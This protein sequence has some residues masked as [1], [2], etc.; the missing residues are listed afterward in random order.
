MNLSPLDVVFLISLVVL[1]FIPWRKRKLWRVLFLIVLAINLG[2]RFDYIR[3]SHSIE[4]ELRQTQQYSQ[5][6]QEELRG[7]QQLAQAPVLTLTGHKMEKI[8]EGYRITLQF[9]SSKNEPLGIIAF[10]A[11]ILGDSDAKIIDFWPI[12]SAG[13]FEH[14]D[15]AKEISSDGKQARLVYSLLSATLP[16]VDLTISKV[17]PLEIQGNYITDPVM[18]TPK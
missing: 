18:I 10:Q 2:I 6:L 15:D 11:T 13:A 7:T 3:N 8:D 17:A 1:V 14:G 5:S 16:T 4:R 9:T 12:T